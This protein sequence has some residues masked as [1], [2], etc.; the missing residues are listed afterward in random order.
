MYHISGHDSTGPY[1]IVG[2]FTVQGGAITAGEQDFSDGSFA[3]TNNLVASGSTLTVAGSNIQIVL[4]TGNTNIGVN[5]IETLRG[6]RVSG[7]RV[8]LS[9]FDAFATGAGSLDLQTSTAAPTGGYVFNVGGVDGSSAQVPLGIGG[10]LNITGTTVSNTMSVFDYNDG[11][12]V[13]QGLLFSSGTVT[14]P[15]S[16]GRITITLV[17][18]STSVPGFTFTGYIV[19]TNRIQL[20]EAFMD[21]LD[22]DLGGTALGQGANAGNFTMANSNATYVFTSA[23]ADAVGNVEIGGSITLNNGLITGTLAVNDLSTNGTAAIAGGTYTVDPTGRVTLVNITPSLNVLIPFAF[24]LYL[25]GNGNALELGVDNSQETVGMAYQQTA[26]STT[27]FAG[28]FALSG[29]GFGVLNNSHPAWS[30]AGPVSVASNAITGFTDY[31]L[32]SGA[33]TSNVSLSGTETSASALLS[34]NGLNAAALQTPNN[35]TYF[36]IDS[37]RVIAIET[38]GQQLGLLQLEG[39]GP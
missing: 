26:A 29:S 11:G 17:P 13:G 33:Q 1:F 37:T 9:E 15:D 32:Q 4:N 21:P 16:F 24:Q 12:S 10:V 39:V 30:A 20:V 34:L 36:Q 35:Y 27:P 19:G 18:S 38:D 8:L 2:A 28:T 14:A 6:P 25:D 7:T 22:G 23:G 3:Y 31:N 5:G